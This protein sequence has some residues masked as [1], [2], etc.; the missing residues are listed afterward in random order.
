MRDSTW[1]ESSQSLNVLKLMGIPI[2]LRVGSEKSTS[3]L[4]GT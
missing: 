4:V 2:I 3:Q 1:Q